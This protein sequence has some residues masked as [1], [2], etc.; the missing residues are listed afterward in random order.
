MR[1]WYGGGDTVPVA[2]QDRFHETFG[3]PLAEGYAMT[4]SILIS[5]NRPGAM[6][7]GSIG[8]PALGVQIEVRDSAGQ[9]LAAGQ[10]GQL[11]VRSPANF[12]GYWED[13]EATTAA[14]DQGWLLTGDLGRFD[15]DGYLWFEGRCKQL[16]SRGGSKISPQEVEAALHQHPAVVEAGVVG[17]PDEVYGQRVLACVVLRPGLAVEPATLREFARE[18]LADYKLPEQV[19]FLEALP[20]GLTGKLDRN[21]LGALA[22]SAPIAT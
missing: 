15:A 12:V 21:A 5:W 19:L 20:R 13:P 8:L 10:T 11:A 3:L 14:L 6:R 7:K 9:A 2:L 18:R 1:T 22:A 16:I 17:L 4:E